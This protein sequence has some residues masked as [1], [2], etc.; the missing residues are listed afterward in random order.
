MTNSQRLHEI[1]VQ[2]EVPF[3]DADPL[4]VAWHGHYYKYFE[5]AR[6]QLL[7]GLGLDGQELLNLN[8]RFLVSESQCRHI[9]ALSY[10][11]V[12]EV[13]AWVREYTHQVFIEYEIRSL[14]HD[15]RCATG[16]TKL[17][18]VNA[19]NELLLRTPQIIQDRITEGSP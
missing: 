15:R 11:E 18:T 16:F 10:A 1:R 17:I 6:A 14:T 5:L 7:R 19:A 13:A 4:A 9:Q 8:Y 3:H 2:H 12:F